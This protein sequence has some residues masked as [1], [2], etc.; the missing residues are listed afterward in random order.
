ML[1]FSNC[2]VLNKTLLTGVIFCPRVTATL[3]MSA[4]AYRFYIP[5]SELDTNHSYSFFKLFF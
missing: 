5:P 4:L 1:L 2:T 3:M